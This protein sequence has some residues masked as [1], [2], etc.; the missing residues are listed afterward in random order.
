M[1]L[2]RSE[3]KEEARSAN[4]IACLPNE[5]LFHIFEYAT[6]SGQP[7]DITTFCAIRL[8]SSTWRSAADDCVLKLFWTQLKIV[9]YPELKPLITQTE[10][11]LEQA[12]CADAMIDLPLS[13]S[14]SDDGYIPSRHPDYFAQF[15]HLSLMF[16]HI[17]PPIRKSDVILRPQAYLHIQTEFNA[18]L[19]KLWAEIRPQ[20][21]FP[22][23]QSPVSCEA[24]REWLHAP[25][26]AE[27]IGLVVNLHLKQLDLKV[28]PCEIY[29][30]ARLNEL[31]LYHANL[32]YIPYAIGNLTQLTTLSL[33]D[34]QL[35][36]LPDTIGN[37]TQLTW[38]SL[39][40]N[41]LTFLPGSIGNL[42]RLTELYLHENDLD[43]I[44]ES[45][46]NLTNLIALSLSENQLE[47]VPD[48]LGNLTR[49]KSLSLSS[50]KLA[51]IP[52]AV[53]LL[54]PTT[55]IQ[56]HNNPCIWMHI[57]FN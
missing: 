14:S 31:N 23:E 16:N 46:G 47:T 19:E 35:A 20:F 49:L 11:S 2:S 50:N 27:Q 41:K 48:T 43:S 40:T 25:Q 30:F 52:Y 38:L 10:A 39:S 13:L 42:T 45:I 4:S 53:T 29:H 12:L 15:F 34:N 5:I 24:I 56:L 55:A 21:H 44:P 54:P 57:A 26:H 28:L 32:S 18:S 36:A 33:Y 17:G 7:E 22:N 1:R 6:G 9:N 51:A 37:L 3:E 8:V